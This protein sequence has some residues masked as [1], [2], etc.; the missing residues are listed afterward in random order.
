MSDITE[1]EQAWIGLHRRIDLLEREVDSHNRYWDELEMIHDRIDKIEAGLVF[2]FSMAIGIGLAEYL[3]LSGWTGAAVVF[4]VMVAMIGGTVVQ[5]GR[6]E[7]KRYDRRR[8]MARQ[9]S[10]LG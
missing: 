8:D 6:A 1:Q 3:D 10:D 5:W 2:V 4:L 9:H 7:A